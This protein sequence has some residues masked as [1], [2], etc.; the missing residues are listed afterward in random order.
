MTCFDDLKARIE[1][2]RGAIE[3]NA[4]ASSATDAGKTSG[5]WADVLADRRNWPDLNEICVF[6]RGDFT[7][8]IGDEHQP[9][10]EREKERSARLQH[11]FRR[12][13]S[14]QFVAGL[15]EPTFGAPL[16]FEHDDVARS[17]SFR[18]N[19]ATTKR[20]I[21]LLDIFGRKGPLR[22]L[23]IGA[24]WG[25]GLLQLHHLL[26]IESCV[27]VDLP[28]NLYLSTIYLATVL[29]KRRLRMLDVAG[30]LVEEIERGT[31]T[32]CLPGS[33]GRIC[34][35]FDLVVN[36]FS[37]QEMDLESVR[38]YIAWIAMVLSD[39]GIFISLNSHAKAGVRRPSDYG[40]DK[41]HIHHW[42]V[43]R[44]SPPGYFNTIPYE[45]VVGR[46]R[47]E[48][49][50]Y[51]TDVQDALGWLMQLGLD[52]DLAGL[53]GR[54]AAGTLGIEDRALLASYTRFFCAQNDAD[55][56]HALQDA[57]KIDRTPI[58][59]FVSAHFA[60]LC[61]DLESSRGLLIAACSR[62]LSG[63]AR[64]RAEVLLAGMAGGASTAPGPA[65]IDELDAAYAYPE[66]ASMLATGDLGPAID[67]AE[68]ILR[69]V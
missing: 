1:F 25:G 59:Q 24:G 5:F 8:G 47:I 3:R 21:E 6:R 39:E 9:D 49:P 60:L 37:L 51:S 42:G 31:I 40:F 20:V 53:C 12:M 58:S 36:A 11:I 50:L 55:R 27:I 68:R 61:G 16:V 15:P 41:F 46:R 35:R 14:S 38:A 23:E 66:V 44:M 48:T 54:F 4:A 29:P 63:F 7:H 52:R 33:I 34:S 65:P 17:T 67:H 13:V 30:E 2:V 19:A 62:G 69:Q 45:V 10:Y 32:A 43:F 57:S 28:Q 56:R 22:V 18:L 64:V 26:D